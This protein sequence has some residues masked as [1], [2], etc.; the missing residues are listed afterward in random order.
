[1]GKREREGKGRGAGAPGDFESRE[2]R[3]RNFSIPT[4]LKF[5]KGRFPRQ[6][7]LI[8]TFFSTSEFYIF[9]LHRP[10]VI[11]LAKVLILDFLHVFIFI[12]CEYLSPSH[13]SSQPDDRLTGKVS[14]CKLLSCVYIILIL[15]HIRSLSC[16]FYYFDDI[17]S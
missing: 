15:F 7:T 3:T 11:P 8:A 17:K 6:Y 12:T 9:Q 5:L 10:R 2:N 1:M 4:F 13:Q 16:R 14:N